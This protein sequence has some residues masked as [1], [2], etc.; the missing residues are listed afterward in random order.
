VSDSS[1][2]T[3]ARQLGSSMPGTLPVRGGDDID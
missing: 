1:Y 3:Q 2:T